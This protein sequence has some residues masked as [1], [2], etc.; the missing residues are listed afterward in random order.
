MK[1]DYLTVE[2]YKRYISLFKLSEEDS[3]EINSIINNDFITVVLV[4]YFLLKKNDKT[5][6]S[7]IYTIRHK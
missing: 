2:D 6:K 4:S 3:K 7:K 5:S 1:N